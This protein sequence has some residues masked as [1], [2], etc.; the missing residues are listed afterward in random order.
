MYALR[1]LEQGL[2][3]L[4]VVSIAIWSL[5]AFTPGDP[6][7]RILQARGILEPTAEQVELLRAELGLDRP[8]I[9]RYLDW[10]TGLVRGDLGPSWA[11]GRPISDEFLSRLPATVL[12]TVVALLL[13][14]ALTMVLG[15]PA[16]L[17]ASRWPDT[18]SRG[19]ALVALSLPSFLIGVVL[20]EVITLRLGLGRVLADGTIA[21]V[22]LPALTLAL[23][24]AATWS[25]LLRTGLLETRNA[26]F[27]SVARGRG[28]SRNYLL[29]RHLLPHAAPP[30]LTV[31]GLSAAALLGGAPVVE[32]VFTWPGVGLYV[33]KAIDTR[34]LPV[35]AATALFAVVVY[36]VTSLVTDLLLVRIDPSRKATT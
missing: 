8:L 13:A 19:F 5:M 28:A 29:T 25:R 16:A 11:T 18:L 27:L 3:S 31:I 20:V 14:L 7:L 24:P 32:T 33:V 35:I 22:F 2:L 34:D 12:L 21:T 1:R 17:W 4:L 36:L 9:L 26:P 30:M 23:G 6:A 10:M 15:I